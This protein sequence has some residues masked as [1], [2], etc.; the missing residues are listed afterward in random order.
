MMQLVRGFFATRGFLESSE[1]HKPMIMF[2]C[3]DPANMVW[4][5]FPDPVTGEMDGSVASCAPWAVCGGCR[6]RR[7]SA[8]T[9]TKGNEGVV[10]GWWGW[11]WCVVCSVQENEKRKRARTVHSYD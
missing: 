2:M 10:D 9:C 11:G 1:S 5:N 3:E 4:Y 7:A 6:C 8:R